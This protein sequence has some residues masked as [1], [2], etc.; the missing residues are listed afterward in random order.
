MVQL[1]VKQKTKANI[2]PKLQ[3]MDSLSM[4]SWSRRA[5]QVYMANQG[6]EAMILQPMFTQ[7]CIICL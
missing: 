1:Y 2:V 6:L 3:V 5:N 4:V 7:R